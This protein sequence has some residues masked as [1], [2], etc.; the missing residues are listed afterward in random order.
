VVCVVNDGNSVVCV[1]N[2]RQL[3][4]WLVIIWDNYVFL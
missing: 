2:G 1:A 4:R 3:G